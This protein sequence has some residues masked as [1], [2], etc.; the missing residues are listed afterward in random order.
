MDSL[1]NL[2]GGLLVMLAV[3][4]M[5]YLLA[6][7]SR[8]YQR[9]VSGYDNREIVL[10]GLRGVAALMVVIYHAALTNSCLLHG[11]WIETGSPEFQGF[12][13]GGVILFFMLSGYLFWSKARQA[14]GKVNPWK[15]WRGRLYRIAPL[16]LF[17]LLLVI[18]LAAFLAGASWLTPA[19]WQPLLRLLTLGALDWHPVGSV[20]L[21]DYNGVVWTLAYEWG[22]YLMLPFI[23]W[24]AT[25]RRIFGFAALVF[26]LLLSPQILSMIYPW[27]KWND[28]VLQ[29]WL[30][31]VFGMLCPVFFEDKTIRA[32]LSHPLAAAVALF[33]TVLSCSLY[34]FFYVSLDMAGALFPVFFVAAAGN[35]FFGFLTHP[36]TRCLGAM[37]F[38]LYLLH[39]IIFRLEIRLIKMAGWTGSSQFCSW[40]IVGLTAMLIALLCSATYRWIEFPFL[41]ISHKKTLG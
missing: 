40:L 29:P 13:S 4:A 19:N 18:L 35:S 17:S 31:F 36:A 6:R 22:F 3:I 23:A 20:D 30:F 32:R 24:L 10:D 26:L 16:Y 8:F 41:S 28:S 33:L 11:A 14:G 12:G 34:Q 15:L 2:T 39:C 37:S 1:G 7:H 25:G 38:S 9:E 5:S 27:E 21:R